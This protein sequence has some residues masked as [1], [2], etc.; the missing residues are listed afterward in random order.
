MELTEARVKVPWMPASGSSI[1][2]TYLDKSEDPCH[3]AL[4]PLKAPELPS[5]NVVTARLSAGRKTVHG[6]PLVK[7][8][9]APNH[10][11]EPVTGIPVQSPE[12]SA[13]KTVR[14]TLA[15]RSSATASQY[16]QSKTVL[17]TGDSFGASSCVPV[18]INCTVL[19]LADGVPGMT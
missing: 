5:P 6:V 14:T 13:V 1:V 7:V 12:G 8:N 2:T 11:V 19:T 10:V 15:E 4:I 16:H 9:M 3:P 17:L 18:D